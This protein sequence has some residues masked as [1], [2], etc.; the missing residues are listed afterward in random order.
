MQQFITLAV[1]VLCV[2]CASQK[3]VTNSRAR[4]TSGLDKYNSNYEYK[5]D[6]NGLMRAT[7]TKR[8]QYDINQTVNYRGRD[9][10]GKRYNT[11][12]FRK[13]RWGGKDRYQV[14]AYNGNID[15]SRFQHAPVTVDQGARSSKNYGNYR[16][17][18]YRTGQ[19]S[20]VAA[21]EGSARQIRTKKSGYAYRQEVQNRKR[22]PVL[23]REQHAQ[24]NIQ[25][26]RALLGR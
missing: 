26:T 18:D 19:Y 9:Y 20:T 11:K 22:P 15:G 3:T 17:V 4:A 2:S 7:S 16:K 23:S 8:S 5:K 1:A 12:D 25:Q 21:Y 24:M 13:N 6:E 14:S 10:S